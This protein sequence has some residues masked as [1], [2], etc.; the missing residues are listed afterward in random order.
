MISDTHTVLPFNTTVRGKAYRHPLPKCD[1]FLHAGDLTKIGRKAE[2]EFIVDMLKKDVQ[3]EI[4]IVIAGNH[5]LAHDKEYYARRGLAR[6]GA[7]RQENPDEVRALY[8]D[9]AARQAGIVYMEE[10]VRSFTLKSGTKST[11]YASPYTPEFYGW[12]FAYERDQDRFNQPNN[13]NNNGDPGAIS[14]LSPAVRDFVPD[15]PGVDIMLTHGP[16]YGI[17]DRVLHGNMSV[18]CE[19]LLRACQRARPR[20]HVFGHIHEA[21]GAVRKNWSK[22]EDVELEEEEDH[23]TVLRNRCRY[24]D[25]SSDSNHP[26]KFGE[27]TLFVN[28]SV[29]TLRYQAD[30]APWM[31][32][33][34]LPAAADLPATSGVSA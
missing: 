21:Y 23:E 32:D 30:N 28:A 5:D 20:L 9:E 31:V 16:P 1:I 11:I 8:T 4:K 29:V 34:D 18:G 3:A 17:L 6:H 2:H 12:A 26:L 24:Y 33:L 13:S 22:N 15:F 25:M 14:T 10:E 27:E 7:G 19:N